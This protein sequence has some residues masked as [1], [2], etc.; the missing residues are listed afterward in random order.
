MEITADVDNNDIQWK[1]HFWIHH[2]EI[3]KAKE[4]LSAK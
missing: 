1:L 3:I 2:P 4:N